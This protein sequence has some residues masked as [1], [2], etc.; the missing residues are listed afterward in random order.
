[1]SAFPWIG[2]DLDNGGLDGDND[3]DL[4]GLDHG[5]LDGDGDDNGDDLEHGGHHEDESDN[6]CDGHDFEF[7]RLRESVGQAKCFFSGRTQ[8]HEGTWHS[9]SWN[10]KNQ[11]NFLLSQCCI[12]YYLKQR[13][14]N[15]SVFEI[16][17]DQ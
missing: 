3:G 8:N 5:G 14:T 4:D 12:F 6:K 7:H 2:D 13:N 11:L 10:D 9:L 17:P 16:L 1:M 15:R